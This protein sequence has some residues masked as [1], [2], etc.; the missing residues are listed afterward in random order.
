MSLPDP[1][2]NDLFYFA[3]VVEHRGFAAAG[4]ALGVPKSKL[5]RRVAVLEQRLGTRLL[6]R[7]SRRFAVTELGELYY[8]HCRAM[9]EE[10]ESAH[11]TIERHHTEPQGT[12]RIS[13]P[14]LLAQGPLS[15]IISG[16]LAR[17]P[18]V[19]IHLDSTNRR[20]DVIQEG[21]DLA[22]RVRP[23]PLD[24]S[25]LVVR[26]LVEDRA[27][28]LA[29]PDYLDRQGRP[30]DPEALQRHDTLDMT[31]AGDEHRFRLVDAD[32]AGR[33][34]RH[35][36]RL[37]TDELVTLRQAALDGLGIV[38]L[39]RVLVEEDLLA[40]RLEAVLPAWRT[41]HALIHAA[42]ASRRGLLPAVRLFIDALAAGFAECPA[43]ART[44]RGGRVSRVEEAA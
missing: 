37:V 23:A 41:P 42:F 26:V 40:G 17:H 38:V 36:P 15:R 13:C 35:R 30:E 11:E 43:E 33:D 25:D 32:G 8:R 14:V 4:R 39:P 7:S 24:D 20:V 9:V 10:A 2:L 1:D 31:R 22:I 28:L 18:R 3:R 29:S 19:R 34:V 21:I 27:L 16:F 5:S 44:T 6:Q 12:L